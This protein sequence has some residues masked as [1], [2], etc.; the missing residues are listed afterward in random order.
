MEQ[1][2]GGT[3]NIRKSLKLQMTLKQN[4]KWLICQV[5]AVRRQSTKF[6]SHFSW[7]PNFP[8]AAALEG[9]IADHLTH[10]QVWAVRVVNG[11]WQKQSTTFAPCSFTVIFTVSFSGTF[12]Y[13]KT[14]HV[15]H[16]MLR[17]CSTLFKTQHFAFE[18]IAVVYFSGFFLKL[19]Q[20][21]DLGQA[22]LHFLRAFIYRMRDGG[23]WSVPPAMDRYPIL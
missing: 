8:K 12:Y 13:D 9:D 17:Y 21:T 22:D 7:S 20:M 6:L 3:C 1:K 10:A 15:A 11:F 19:W 2:Q 18:I 4:H 16:S 5:T 14:F 23:T